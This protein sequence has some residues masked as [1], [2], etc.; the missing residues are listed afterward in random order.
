[1]EYKEILKGYLPEK[2]VDTIFDWIVENK[3]HL[4]I[5]PKRKTKLGDYR[6]PIKYGN[7]RI[8][9]NHDL[10]KYSFL[11]TLVHEFA[12][13]LV[14]EKHKS[15]VK[16]HGKEWKSTYRELM[17]NFTG[18]GVFPSDIEE[19]LMQS[20]VN[21]KASSSSEITLSRCLKKYDD[22]SHLPSLEEL[23][24]NA[25]FAIEGGRKFIKGPKRRTRYK[26]Q[27]LSDK[28]YYMVHALTPVYSH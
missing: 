9:I 7:H 2:S 4:K 6:P 23:K 8:S 24:E 3:V 5:A 28:K 11:I 14:W 20:I 22:Q 17:L 25:V 10:N 15:K 12:H 13:L 18:K 19:P 26:C 16:A 21:S 27:C 1:M